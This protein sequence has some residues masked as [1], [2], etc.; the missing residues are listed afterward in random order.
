MTCEH[1]KGHMPRLVTMDPRLNTLI[2]VQAKKLHNRESTIRHMVNLIR[3]EK[4]T[5]AMELGLAVIKS[6]SF[7]G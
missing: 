4:E 5:E 3:C 1:C 2:D 7:K 6:Q